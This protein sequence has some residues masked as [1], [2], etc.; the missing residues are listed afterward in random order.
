MKKTKGVVEPIYAST[1]FIRDP[2]NQK[3]INES[4]TV[5]N[6]KY[7]QTMASVKQLS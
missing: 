7:W 2:G 6:V 1:T 3:R 5:L 4:D